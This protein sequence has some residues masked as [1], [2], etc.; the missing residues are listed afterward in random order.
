MLLKFDF[1]GERDDARAQFE[2][3]RAA[4]VTGFDMENARRKEAG[5]PPLKR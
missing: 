2:A 4:G 3:D 1:S 5:L